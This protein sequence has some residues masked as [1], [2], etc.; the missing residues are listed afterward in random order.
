MGNRIGPLPN[1]GRLQCPLPNCTP[2]P[3]LFSATSCPW[4]RTGSSGGPDQAAPTGRDAPNVSKMKSMAATCCCFCNEKKKQ[5]PV[6]EQKGMSF[7]RVTPRRIVL[8]VGL[9]GMRHYVLHI[10]ESQSGLGPI[11]CGSFHLSNSKHTRWTGWQN[12]FFF[13]FLHSFRFF[14]LQGG[15]CTCLY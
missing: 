4:D 3:F 11:D 6:P 1:D 7:E 10:N 13:F 14:C 2:I 12:T 15:Q 8:S 9:S 5:T